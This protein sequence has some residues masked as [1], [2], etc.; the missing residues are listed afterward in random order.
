MTNA[1][2]QTNNAPADADVKL[3]LSIV[4]KSYVVEVV[5]PSDGDIAIKTFTIPADGELTGKSP[6]INFIAQLIELYMNELFLEL[7]HYQ[8]KND[9]SDFYEEWLA[10]TKEIG[11][12]NGWILDRM[13]TESNQGGH[14]SVY[15]SNNECPTE[16]NS[17]YDIRITLSDTTQE[18]FYRVD[19]NDGF[20]D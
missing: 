15:I 16:V 8:P 18:R 5:E 14:Q 11:R 3:D 12:I 4:S 6:V 17:D 10:R 19:A 20:D 13:P 7:D 2:T 9:G 1:M